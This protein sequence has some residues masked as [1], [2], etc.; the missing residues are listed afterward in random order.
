MNIARAVTGIKRKKIWRIIQGRWLF[1]LQG[2]SGN[3][4]SGPSAP[5]LASDSPPSEVGAQGNRR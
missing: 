5:V 1:S 3:N 2:W 4:L